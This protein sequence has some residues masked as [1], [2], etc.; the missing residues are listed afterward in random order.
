MMQIHP[1]SALALLSPFSLRMHGVHHYI[2]K[3]GFLCNQHLVGGD[4][5]GS[6]AGSDAGSVAVCNMA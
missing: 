6:D 5:E 3:S 4:G 1:C 2:F